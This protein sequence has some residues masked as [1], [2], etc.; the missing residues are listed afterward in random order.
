LIRELG[1]VIIQ[2]LDR[3]KSEELFNRINSVSLMCNHL[4]VAVQNPDFVNEENAYENY[5]FFR[6]NYLRMVAEL[7]KIN[8]RVAAIHREIDND[9]RHNY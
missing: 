7:S 6:E 8:V 9:E 4:K 3:N 2:T 5:C 1:G